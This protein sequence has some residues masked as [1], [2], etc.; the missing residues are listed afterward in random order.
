MAWL[1]LSFMQDENQNG[2]ADYNENKINGNEVGDK[3]DLE[4]RNHRSQ[5]E[6]EANYKQYGNGFPR[7]EPE[8]FQPVMKV[9]SVLGE[10]T[11]PFNDSPGKSEYR[12][13]NR[14]K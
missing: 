13:R 2:Y 11:D 1:F 5:I 12:I 8:F 10:R 4:Y 3:I 6:I 14:D 7:S 9:T